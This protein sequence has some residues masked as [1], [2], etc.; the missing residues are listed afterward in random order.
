MEGQSIITTVSIPTQNNTYQALDGNAVSSNFDARYL[1]SFPPGYRFQ[2]FDEELIEYYLKKKVNNEDLPPNKIFEVNLYQFNPKELADMYLSRGQKE[3]YFF[4]PRER[5]YRNGNRPNRAAGDGY[6]KATGA[7]KAI[8]FNGRKEGAKKSLVFYAGKPPKGVKTNWIMH[9]FTLLNPPQRQERGAYGMR[10][11]DWV[12]CRIYENR[13]SGLKGRKSQDQDNEVEAQETDGSIAQ[14]PHSVTQ[15]MP[16]SY[17]TMLLG[18]NVAPLI[19][20]EHIEMD[21]FYHYHGDSAILLSSYDNMLCPENLPF[22]A[23][24]IAIHT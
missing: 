19:E 2:P 12:L 16:I 7:D 18:E 17:S 24:V 11:D 14:T 13:G 22:G 3:M 4:T 21:S 15:Q 1:E 6:W 10:L 23:F 20:N 8:K 5:K 9:E